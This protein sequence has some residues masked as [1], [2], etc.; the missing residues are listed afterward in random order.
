MTGQK[1]LSSISHKGDF[2]GWTV[3]GRKNVEKSKPRNTDKVQKFVLV[4][5]N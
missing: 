2:F 5:I 3:T 4:I 1:N